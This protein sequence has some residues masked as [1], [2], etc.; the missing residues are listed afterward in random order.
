M[1][2]R[3]Q[4]R[5]VPSFARRARSAFYADNTKTRAMSTLEAWEAF[6]QRAADAGRIWLE[7]LRAIERAAIDAILAEVPPQ[8][9]SHISREFTRELLLENQRRLLA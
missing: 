5:Q 3:D 8:R 6:S 2:S 4:G 1:E 9:M 7:Q